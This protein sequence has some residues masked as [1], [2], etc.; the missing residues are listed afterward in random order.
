MPSSGGLRHLRPARRRLL[1]LLRPAHQ[2]AIT[3]TFLAWL[4]S[5]FEAFVTK[6]YVPTIP[7]LRAWSGAGEPCPQCVTLG[8]FGMRRFV[9]TRRALGC[10]GHRGRRLASPV[11]PLGRLDRTVVLVTCLRLIGCGGCKTDQ[12]LNGR[13]HWAW[14]PKRRRG[15]YIR[16]G[17]G[18]P[19]YPGHRFRSFSR[20]S[21]CF[22]PVAF[23]I[24]TL[25]LCL[26]LATLRLRSTLLFHLLCIEV[27]TPSFPPP[28]RASLHTAIYLGLGL[29]GGLCASRSVC[30][31]ARRL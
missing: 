27:A 17:E 21:C 31:L 9:H 5:R 28:R 11:S 14:K 13:N 1:A 20:L 6:N 2:S 10:S 18:D 23:P 8:V 7:L 29:V 24:S 22:L 3:L 19:S 30:L 16:A 25:A 26:R 4:W 12:F 15:G